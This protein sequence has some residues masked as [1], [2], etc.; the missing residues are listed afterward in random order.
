M[1]RI[2]FQVFYFILNE[3]Q[4]T[5]YKCHL[6]LLDQLFI[7]QALLNLDIILI[8]ILKQINSIIIHAFIHIF[9]DHL[10][11]LMALIFHLMFQ[12]QSYNII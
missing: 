5:V 6:L 12:H 9:L 10:Y 3:I 1:L 4:L 2:Y 8:N 7:K 11:F